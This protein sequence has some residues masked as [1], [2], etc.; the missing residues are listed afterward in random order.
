MGYHGADHISTGFQ[1]QLLSQAQPLDVGVLHEVVLDLRRWMTLHGYAV[2]ETPI[3]EVADLFL[4]KAGDQ[5][6]QKLFTFERRGRELAL[7]PEFTAPAAHHY[8]TSATAQGV[9]RWQF[10][11]PVF[12]D[13]PHHMSLTF[14]RTSVGAELIGMSEPHA[15]AEIIAMAVGG[16]QVLG[17]SGW[18]LLLGHVGLTRQ[19]LA[20]FNL[21]SRTQQFLLSRL[22]NIKDHGKKEILEQ[23]VT[24]GLPVRDGRVTAVQSLTSDTDI[25][26][27]LSVLLHDPEHGIAM[28]GRSPEDIARRVW[29]KHQ[30]LSDRPA[31]EAAL[32][33][34]EE[35]VAISASP[36]E[37]FSLIEPLVGVEDTARHILAEW[38]R[39]IDL[40]AVYEVPEVRITV[41]PALA[42]DWEYYTG[43]VFELRTEAN[44]H[45]GGGGR[46]DE[47]ARLIGAKHDI[48]AVGFAYYLD[49]IL[50][51]LHRPL[52]A[53]DIRVTI[54][55][56]LENEKKIAFWARNLRKHNFIVVVIS[57][58]Y[59]A[60]DDHLVLE[61]NPDGTAQFRQNIYAEAQM[62][63]LLAELSA[64]KNA[65]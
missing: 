36:E 8:A 43:V 63:A 24:T 26:Q 5:V 42:R 41:E 9:A 1:M 2:V 54:P 23:L 6:V 64:V 28:G 25:Q 31:I 18:H 14:Q 7:R 53:R 59:A 46:Y 47:L 61:I 60:L 22:P 12:E 49:E 40:I 34:L 4:T 16:L 21:D 50:G 45:L 30:R 35:W 13:D 37:A 29:Q 62:D 17:V 15:D 52:P 56:T 39:V 3:I 27:L 51:E 55:L 11:G 19:L 44:R 32:D 65:P 20:R 58:P 38:R 57:H 33:F 10:D 48:P